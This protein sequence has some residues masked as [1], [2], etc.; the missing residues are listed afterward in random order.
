MKKS[1][2]DIFQKLTLFHLRKGK[3][4]MMTIF[5]FD[6][7]FNI[8]YSEIRK[9]W[10]Y[11]YLMSKRKFICPILQPETVKTKAGVDIKCH[12]CHLCSVLIAFKCTKV[13]LEWK[14]KK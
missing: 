7:I 11:C 14:R 8:K 2:Q 10:L 13:K 9:N 12:L 6:Y 3:E 1:G 4:K 5:I